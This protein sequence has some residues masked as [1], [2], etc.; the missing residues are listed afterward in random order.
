MRPLY[1]QRRAAGKRGCTCVRI[2]PKAGTKYLLTSHMLGVIFSNTP[3]Y[4]SSTFFVRV[5]ASFEPGFTVG[6]SAILW[7]KGT[8]QLNNDKYHLKNALW[9][10]VIWELLN[11]VG[12]M[13][14]VITVVYCRG[15]EFIKWGSRRPCEGRRTKSTP[16]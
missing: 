10:E 12:K 9:T 4:R 5:N 13:S 14:L 7:D 8:T 3:T 16:M 1:E 2:W 15:R 11:S 6:T